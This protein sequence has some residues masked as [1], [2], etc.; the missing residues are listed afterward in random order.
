FHSLFRA[1]CPPVVAVRDLLKK[2]EGLNVRKEKLSDTEWAAFK[3]DIETADR[4]TIELAAAMDE[5]GT[6]H[7][8]ALDW[9]DGKPATVP[10][11]FLFNQLIVHGIHH[12][13]QLSQ[14][15][16]EMGVEHDFSGID[17]EFLG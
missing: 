11:H 2:T 16:D 10:Y 15:L 8:I 4:A 6:S 14:I 5:A 9:Y 7:P 1:S 12:R 13:G 17:L 3:A